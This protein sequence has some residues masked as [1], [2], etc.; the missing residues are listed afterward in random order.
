M[1]VPCVRTGRPSPQL[2]PAPAGRKLPFLHNQLGAPVLRAPLLG[3]IGS[4]RL[5]LSIAV[6]ADAPVG[7]APLIMISLT[8]IAR[9][10][11]RAS[12]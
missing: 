6:G 3:L 4:N 8:T 12:C 9:S 11:E 7:N 10:R 1:T 2:T 5:L